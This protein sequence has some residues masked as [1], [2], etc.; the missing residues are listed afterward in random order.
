MSSI[1]VPSYDDEL[2]EDG[3]TSIY[4]ISSSIRLSVNC[5]PAFD[6]THVLK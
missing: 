5:S 3:F 4:L 1:L 6:A 2:S